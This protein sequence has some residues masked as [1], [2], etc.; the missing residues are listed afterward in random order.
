[1]IRII[2]KNFRSN[3]KNF[4]IFF[5]SAIVSVAII[6]SFLYMNE[7]T[8]KV[9]VN[10][11]ISFAGW[12]IEKLV[13]ILVIA[14]VFVMVYSTKFYIKTRI[15]DYSIFIILGIRHKTMQIFVA[16]EYLLSWIVA[17]VIGLLSGNVIIFGFKQMLSAMPGEITYANLN[18]SK[19][20]KFT[21]LWC[22]LLL[23][24]VMIA[25]Y[26]NLKEQDLSQLMQ[27][28]VEIE[29]KPKLK[30]W[31]VPVILGAACVIGSVNTA[32][33]LNKISKNTGVVLIIFCAIGIFLIL[34]YGINA[35][36][37]IVR[38]REK[39]YYKKIV[40]WNHFYYRFINNIN[41][42]FT[43]FLIGIFCIYFAWFF[44]MLGTALKVDEQNY[45]YDFLCQGESSDKN[46][47]ETF[48]KNYDEESYLFT[49]TLVYNKSDDPKIGISEATYEKLWKEKLNL[50]SGEIHYLWLPDN[51]YDLDKEV[52]EESFFYIGIEA[53][54]SNQFQTFLIKGEEQGTWFGK[55]LPTI[56]VFD[57][58]DFEKSLSEDSVKTEILVGNMGNSNNDAVKEELSQLK[59]SSKTITILEKKDL[60]N[61]DNLNYYVLLAIL[62]F[63]AVA[64]VFYLFFIISIKIFA[65]VPLMKDKYLFLDRLGMKRK[66]QKKALKKEIYYILVPPVLMA[67]ILGATICV[68]LTAKG[69]DL[70]GEVGKLGGLEWILPQIIIYVILEIALI[71]ILSHKIQK[72]VFKDN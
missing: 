53:K 4:V 49:S 18:I 51:Y 15:K 31:K 2:L 47:M 9:K 41:V 64:V 71:F 39:I 23:A 10:G 65:D 19:I 62:A 37:E 27:K 14:S 12:F 69:K 33:L 52:G 63:A 22:V 20:Y 67:V 36:F 29:K 34:R 1:M 11:T 59:A 16:S 7:L 66:E 3:F 26:Q 58:N 24:G 6:F 5:L 45:P 35:F 68:G 54:M 8:D 60:L 28:G 21:I 55:Y 44:F 17:I 57:N 42:I 38:K 32:F 30:Y 13:P 61:S 56:V 43:Q 72:E 46:A 70:I 50:K 40:V 48:H 25:V